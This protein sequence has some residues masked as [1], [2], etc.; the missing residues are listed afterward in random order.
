MKHLNY[1]VDYNLCQIFRNYQKYTRVYVKA[2]L[3]E[4][5][6]NQIFNFY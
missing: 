4:A 5:T 1:N 2:F 6:E 3:V